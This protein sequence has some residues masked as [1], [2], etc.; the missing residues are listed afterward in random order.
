[1]AIPTQR[2]NVKP[3][4]RQTIK[5]ETADM[6]HQCAIHNEWDLGKTFTSPHIWLFES[7]TGQQYG[8]KRCSTAVPCSL[9]YGSVNRD[10]PH[11]CQNFSVKIY[12]HIVHVIK[13]FISSLQSNIPRTL[14]G[15]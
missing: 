11:D 6:D 2:N 3:I 7:D 9:D 12:P 15:I 8:F 13:S 1:M 5:A 14:S 4:E 10:V